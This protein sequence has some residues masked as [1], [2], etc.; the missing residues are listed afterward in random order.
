MDADA[1]GGGQ[2]QMLDAGVQRIERMAMQYDPPCPYGCRRELDL[3]Q[4]TDGSSW[5]LKCARCGARSPIATT[6]RL[7]LKKARKWVGG[8][9]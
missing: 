5:F 7:A 9:G 3:W 8:R 1:V 2:A 4:A 6:K